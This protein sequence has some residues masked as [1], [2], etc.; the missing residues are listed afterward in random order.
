MAQKNI[1]YLSGGLGN[2]MFQYAFA[3]SLQSNYN[4]KFESNTTFYNRIFKDQTTREIGLNLFNLKFKDCSDNKLQR[5]ILKIK[6]KLSNINLS[7]NSTYEG[8]ASILS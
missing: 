1:V 6:E 7:I 2:Q 8:V 3:K 4:I 5:I